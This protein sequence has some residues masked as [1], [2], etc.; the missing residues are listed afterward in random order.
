MVKVTEPGFALL[1]VKLVAL[2]VIVTDPCVPDTSNELLAEV[3]GLKLISP[4]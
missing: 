1:V 4:E 2:G 3:E